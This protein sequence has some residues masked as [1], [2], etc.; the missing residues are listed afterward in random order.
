MILAAVVAEYSRVRRDLL[1][2]FPE[3][4]DDAEMLRDSLDGETA[5][6]DVVRSLIRGEKEDKA[7]A[8]AMRNLA[9][10]YEGRADYWAKRAIARRTA[11]MRLMQAMGERKITA[12]EFTVSLKSLP[13]QIDV[14]DEEALPQE[15]WDYQTVRKLARERLR[16]AIDAGQDV[17]GARKTNGDETIQVRS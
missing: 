13:P 17:P 2:T 5:A 12:P 11:A 14:Y 9:S 8:I 16:A 6:Q 4:A 7:M 10:T 1:E 3:L 15:F